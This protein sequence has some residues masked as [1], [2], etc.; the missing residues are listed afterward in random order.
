MEAPL[1]ARV[2]DEAAEWLM[3]LHDSGA[4][5]ADRAAWERWR[6]ADPEHARA[7]ARAELLLGKL[8]GLPPALALPALDR[9]ARSRRRAV[10]RLAALLALAPTGWMAWRM[11]QDQGWTADLRTATGERRTE[12]LADGSQVMLDTASAVDVRF[13]AAW[14]LLTLRHGAISVE[15]AN[16]VATPARPFAVDT[17]LGRLRALGTRF[18]VRTDAGGVRLA[19]AEGAV[20]VTLHGAASAALVVPAGHQTVLTGRGVQPPQPLQPEAMAWTH[21]MLMADAMPLADF[22]AELSRYRSGLLHCAPEVR[23]LRVSG[24]FPLA[25]TSRTLGML[26]STYPVDVHMRMHGYWVTVAARSG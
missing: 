14:R 15:T 6:Q 8:G 17:S 18:A 9:P 3:R 2:L 12:Q 25:D 16:D 19:V 13:D 5:A 23:G 7:W 21:G 10:A 20:Q 1:Q 11:A 26:A 4:T 24:A 22:C